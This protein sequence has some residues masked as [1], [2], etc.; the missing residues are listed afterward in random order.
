MRA[1]SCASNEEETA[2]LPKKECYNG[3]HEVRPCDNFDAAGNAVA[4]GSR[5][6]F[7]EVTQLWHWASST[8]MKDLDII[9]AWEAT[10]KAAGEGWD[11]AKKAY[12][13]H[14]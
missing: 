10:K 11:A 5:Y 1:G 4:G 3:N 8:E 2:P 7:D 13:E 14:K 12:D 9:S 6:V